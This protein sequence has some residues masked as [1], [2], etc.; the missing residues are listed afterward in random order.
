MDRDDQAD[1]IGNYQT[2][3]E[4]EIDP[5]ADHRAIDHLATGTRKGED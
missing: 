4:R 3:I 2:S 1:A 5:V